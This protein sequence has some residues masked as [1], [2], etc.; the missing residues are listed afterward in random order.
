MINGS[1]TVDDMRLIVALGEIFE[2]SPGTLNLE[3][4]ASR[5]KSRG[6]PVG[7]GMTREL[8]DLETKIGGKQQ[9][10]KILLDRQRRGSTMRRSGADIVQQMRSVLQTL[11]ELKT[12]V[13]SGRSI[14]RIGLT[15]SLATNL[16]PRVLKESSF[17]S[18]FPNVDLEIV[19]GE[20]HE[21]V[22]LLQTRVDFAVGPK[23]VSNGFHS[24]PLC[25]WKR[26][27]LYSRKVQYKNDFSR[28]VPSATLREWLR[29][30]VVLTPVPRII[31][32]VEKFLKPML[33]GR[34]LIVPQAALRRL[35]VELGIGLAISYEEKRST[36][37]QNDTIG[38][39]DLSAELGTTEMHLYHS[40]DQHLSA[41]ANALMDAIHSIFSREST[42]DIARGM[43]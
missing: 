41:A 42:D 6:F 38:S 40:P 21:L 2:E 1:L 17:L 19:E 3:E 26:V 10:G 28:P 11:E 14:V 9:C 4:V 20:P 16:F 30:E 35:W 36:I 5:L 33:T 13:D 8:N 15:N 22:G 23:D 39:I 43:S 32:K 31:P 7:N 29:H 27:L 12:S 24:K 34:R 25:Q 18:L 37:P